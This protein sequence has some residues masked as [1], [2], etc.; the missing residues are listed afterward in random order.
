MSHGTRIIISERDSILEFIVSR[1][2]LRVYVTFV[3]LYVIGP[4]SVMI[5][6]KSVV[7]S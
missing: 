2:K 7:T 3:S 4:C 5:I 6:N 1:K